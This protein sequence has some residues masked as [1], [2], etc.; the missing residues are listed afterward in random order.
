MGRRFLYSDEALTHAVEASVSIA[1]VMRVLGIK[2]AGGSHFHISKRIKALGLDT[3]HF[4][5]QAHRRGGRFP[6]KAAV[7]ILI[8]YDTEGR[9][10]KT[11]HLRRALLEIGREYACSLCGIS[12]WQDQPIVLHV[13]HIDGHAENCLAENLRFICPNCHSQTPS[14]CRKIASRQKST[15]IQDRML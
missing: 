4:T 6:K 9:R 8:A 10:A 2:H 13:D 7:E 15:Q 14:Y 1:G 12:L 3:S 11:H 5:G